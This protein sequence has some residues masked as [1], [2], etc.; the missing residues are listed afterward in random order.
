MCDNPDCHHVARRLDFLHEGL[1]YFRA[2]VRREPI[3]EGV[4]RCPKCMSTTI[5]EGEIV[6]IVDHGT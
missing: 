2:R 6:E 5:S 1:T 3:P 4:L